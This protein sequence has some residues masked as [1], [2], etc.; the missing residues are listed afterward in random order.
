MYLF[1][2]VIHRDLKPENILMEGG[3]P[4]IADFGLAGVMAPFNASGFTL[5]CGTPEFTAPEIVGGKE[6]EG[7]AVSKTMPQ[8]MCLLSQHGFLQDYIST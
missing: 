6:Y 3:N 7:P 2:R 1:R 5:Q 8:P 4:K